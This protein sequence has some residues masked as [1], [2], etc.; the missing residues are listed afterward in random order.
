[1]K[2]PIDIRWTTFLLTA[3]VGLTLLFVALAPSASAELSFGKC[4]IF[5]AVHVGVPLVLLQGAQ[6]AV[7][8]WAHRMSDWASVTLSGLLGALVFVP[9]AWGLDWVFPDDDDGAET[10]I[11]A[12]VSETTSTVVPVMLVWVA[13]NAPRLLR[14]AEV[15]EASPATETDAAP[16]S[17]WGKVP[18][19]LGR[20]LV[21]L[22]AELHYVRVRTTKGDALVLYPFGKAVQ[23]LTTL[24]GQQV[25]RSHWVALP[26]IIDIER[27]GDGATVHLTSGASLPVSRRF[28]KEATQAWETASVTRANKAATRA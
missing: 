22:S 12:L 23:E 18:R 5:W 27:R 2:T 15:T 13:L 1:M 28:R 3:W 21:S 14:I 8:R 16:A 19:D 17:F 6:M 25:H 9:V 4:V 11:S 26:H 10:W 7:S 20:D 24:S